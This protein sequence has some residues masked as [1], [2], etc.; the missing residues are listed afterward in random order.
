VDKVT[1]NRDNGDTV[2]VR[3][4]TGLYAD[5]TIR[6]KIRVAG[7]Q[8]TCA[9]TA[10]LTYAL[11]KQLND[12]IRKASLIQYGKSATFSN[13][14]ATIEAGEPIPPHNSCTTQYSWC[15]E[16]GTGEKIVENSVW[17]KFIANETGYISI[18]SSGFDN[19]IALY[20]AIS[21]Q[22]ILNQNFTLLAAND[23]RSSTDFNPLIRTQKVTPGKTYWLQV[24]GSGGG[25][26]G[27]FNLQLTALIVTGLAPEKEDVL[28]V[29]PQPAKD[30]VYIKGDALSSFHVHLS[31]YS[32]AGDLIYGET[33][34][35]DNG[36]IVVNIST[37]NK[38]VYVAKIES[39]NNLFIT[40]IVKF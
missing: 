38:G 27:S 17:F 29:Y 24:D 39:G 10:V 4:V 13:K 32:A 25:T 7:T 36:S 40:R 20:D 5:S 23:D 35:P 30:L 8:G 33:V 11:I 12:S 3:A 9:D 22:D 14:C 31:V 34:Q 19:E 18:S 15:D 2:L 21:Y 37:W 16:Y 26:V 28:V 1:L 6:V